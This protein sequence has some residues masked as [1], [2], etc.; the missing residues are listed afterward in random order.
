MF[1]LLLSITALGLVSSAHAAVIPRQSGA[2]PSYVLQHAPMSYLYSGEDYWPSDVATHLQHVIPENGTKKVAN[3]VDFNTIGALGSGIYLTSKDDPYDD[4]SWLF[5]NGSPDSSGFTTAPATIVAVAKPGGIVDAFYFYFYSFDYATVSSCLLSQ[6]C[7]AL[8]SDR[9]AQF[10]D[11]EFGDHVGDWEHSMI[12]FVNG[13]PQY[14]YLSAHSGGAAYTFNAVPSLNGRPYTYI[15]YGTHANY[16]S[17][18]THEHDFPGLD[19]YCDGGHLWDVTRNFRGYWFDTASQKF[20]VA[21]GANIGGQVE[22]G[23]GIGWLQFPGRWG[24]Q[25]YALFHDGQYCVGIPDVATECKLV[26][27]PTGKITVLP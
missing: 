25:E 18:G 4:P 15:G 9:L 11:M 26:D 21:S 12:R 16:A 20:S 23:E 19:D 22:G 8:T 24:D 6:C 3:S 17:P 1:S 2:L 14:L 7:I 10:L 5:G 27:G 13:V